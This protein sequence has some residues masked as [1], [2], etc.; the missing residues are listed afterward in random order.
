MSKLCGEYDSLYWVGDR[1]TKMQRETEWLQ[2]GGDRCCQV[3]L[4]GFLRRAQQGWEQLRKVSQAETA[5][6]KGKVDHFRKIYDWDG[7][8]GEYK[9]GVYPGQV[10]YKHKKKEKS[11][12]VLLTCFFS[13]HHHS[14]LTSPDGLSAFHLVAGFF[15]QRL[16]LKI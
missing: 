3:G 15:T 14:P 10:N 8:K 11:Q 1:Q 5:T 16:Q 7:G 6:K 12:A 9:K 2:V 13:R 4:E